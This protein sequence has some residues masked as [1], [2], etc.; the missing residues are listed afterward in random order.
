M[1]PA[2]LEREITRATE[3]A[4]AF[5]GRG[6]RELARVMWRRVA[7]LVAQRSPEM[8]RRLEREKGLA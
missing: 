4:L 1:S 3:A 7:E 6:Q 5:L 8:V 2:R